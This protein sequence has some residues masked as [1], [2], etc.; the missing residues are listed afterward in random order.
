MLKRFSVILIIFICFTTSLFAQTAYNGVVRDSISNEG[1]WHVSIVAYNGRSI[2]AYTFTDNNGAFRINIPEGKKATSLTFTNIG[3]AKKAIDASKFKNGQTILL[4]EQMTELKEVKVK[5]NG[6]HLNNDTLSYTVNMFKQAQDRSIAD[7]LAR[8]PG[9]NV[10]ENGAILYQG[11]PISKFYVEGMDLV[12]SKYAQVSENLGADKVKRVEVLQRHQPVKMLRGKQFSDQTALNIVLSDDAKSQWNGSMELGCGAQTQKSIGEDVLYNARL[13]TMMFG[14]NIQSVSM[15]KANNTGKDIAH[16]IRDL[17]QFDYGT[18]ETTHW[19]SDITSSTAE[20]AAERSNFNS[21]HLAATNWLKRFNEDSNIRLQMTYLF[22]NTIGQRSHQTQY[23]DIMGMPVVEEEYTTSKYRREAKGELQYKKNSSQ[24]YID[25]TIRVSMNWNTSTAQT[26][27]N[28]I[29]LNQKVQPRQ[30][31]ITDVFAFKHMYGN[32]KIFGFNASLGYD[33]MPSMLALIDG[34]IQRLNI[35]R[36]RG[37]ATTEYRVRISGFSIVNKLGVEA[38]QDKAK[39]SIATSEPTSQAMSSYDAYLRPSLSYGRG[40]FNASAAL[41]LRYSFRKL[42]DTHCNGLLFEPTASVS[43]AFNAA[44]DVSLAASHNVTPYNFHTVCTLP[45]FSSYISRMAGTGTMENVHI[46]RMSAYFKYGNPI[47]GLFLNANAS[48]IA[49]NNNPVFAGTMDG[50]IHVVSTTDMRSDTRQKSLSA[51]LTKSFALG[52]FSASLGGDVYL[53]N[54]DVLLD[55]RLVPFSMNTLS[56]NMK[57]SYT[58]VNEVSVEWTSNMLGSVQ[59]NSESDAQHTETTS[60]RHTMKVDVTPGKWRFA[61]LNELYH[62]NDHSV[63][64]AFFSNVSIRYVARRYDITLQANN[65]FG[66][67]TCDRLVMTPSTITHYT[68]ALRP[69]EILASIAFYL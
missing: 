11:K 30:R 40:K 4:N 10:E 51:Q 46:D 68:C 59:Q 27:L 49:L 22:D 8:M 23:M 16:E 45:Y 15:Y 21:T 33:Y 39:Q 32:E 67:T 7:V 26:T 1:L 42:C 69:R 17:A 52:R 41:P 20:L 47:T 55:N 5:S 25:N 3:Y 19:V 65:I 2:V 12:S 36:L 6:I 58:P 50:S 64:T 48:Y 28:G 29:S 37:I 13:T 62:S 57:L 43:Y 63:N 31:N 18:A 56:G 60:F 35:T 14:R 24:T 66:S 38:V 53:Y 44:T 61:W 9:I 34:N 54:Y